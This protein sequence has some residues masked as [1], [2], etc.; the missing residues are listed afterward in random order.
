MNN[1]FICG[2]IDLFFYQSLDYGIINDLFY[3][4]LKKHNIDTVYSAMRTDFDHILRENFDSFSQSISSKFLHVY[5]TNCS[6]QTYVVEHDQMNETETLTLYDKVENTEIYTTVYNW[7][8]ER[9]KYMIT[10]IVDDSDIAVYFAKEAKKR[11][12]KVIFVF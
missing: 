9:C 8:M 12:I 7:M 10:F 3:K 2:D 11:G 1:C 4:F 5:C 6:Y